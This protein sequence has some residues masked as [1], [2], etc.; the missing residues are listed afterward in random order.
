MDNKTPTKGDDPKLLWITILY[1]VLLLAILTAVTLWLWDNPLLP[2]PKI[3]FVPI[4]ILEWS[5]AGG[6]VAVLYRLAYQRNTTGIR[7]YTWV[8]AKPII[9][10]FMGAIVYFLAVGGVLLLGT[11]TTVQPSAQPIDPTMV[12]QDKLWLNAFAFIGGFSDRFSVD[13]IKRVI[14]GTAI[15]RDEAKSEQQTDDDD[16]RN[17]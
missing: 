3:A 5:F 11:Q 2:N 15:A 10:L 14:S 6:M 4:A 13:L 12:L 16:S 8:V 1:E 17:G 7:L 9:G